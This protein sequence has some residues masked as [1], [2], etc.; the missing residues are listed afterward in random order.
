[1]KEMMVKNFHWFIIAYAAFGLFTVWEE[2]ME[3][4]E[5]AKGSVPPMEAKII[6]SKRKI[7]EIKKFKK[8]LEQSKER[9]Q[10]VVKQIEKIQRQLPSD[11]ND[12]EV[13]A[14]ISNIAQDLRVKDPRANPGEEKDEGFYFEKKYKFQGVGTYLQFLIFFENLEKAERILNVKSLSLILDPKSK[15]SRFPIVNLETTVESFRYN[16]NYKE[17]SLVNEI[18]NKFN[19]N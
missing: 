15:T 6:K 19:T 11:V 13:Q 7:S 14:L 18:E 2:K 1:M 3:E 12:T 10:E 4:I 17:P 8:N 16:T 9:V 5:S